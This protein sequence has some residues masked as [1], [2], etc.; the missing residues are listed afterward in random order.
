M[1]SKTCQICKQNSGMYPLCKIHLQMKEQ[2][3]VFKN[4]ITGKWELITPTN[5]KVIENKKFKCPIC[6]DEFDGTQ[7]KVCINCHY[8]IL[9]RMDELDKNQKPFKLKDYYFNAKDYASRL[10][11]EDKIHYQEI[12]MGAIANILSEN[13]NDESIL[14]RIDKDFLELKQN[15]N[16]K[17]NNLATK[18]KEQKKVEEIKTNNDNEKAKIK[19]TQDGHFV[20]SEY[21]IR[22]DDILYNNNIIHAYN[23]KVDEIPERTIMCDWYIPILR[24]KGIYIELWGVK[25]NE[26]YNKN[27]K[28][29]IDLYKLHSLYL[30]EIEYDE[31]KDDTLRLKSKLLSDIKKFK[32]EILEKQL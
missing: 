31:L 30:I 14:D 16:K 29:K 11:D 24:D 12:T 19:R 28:E 25:D 21:E 6:N 17:N 13:Y 1:T 15:L 9:D 20:E 18:I 27:K 23:I 2:G 26:K 5:E 3:L 10:Y 4:N 7:Y 8:D 22:I 32:K